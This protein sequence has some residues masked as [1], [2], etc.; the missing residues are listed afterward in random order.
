MLSYN[1]QQKR[2]IL[3]EYGRNIQR[4]VDYCLTIPDRE[5]R[6]RCAY[7]IVVSM[8]N[9]FPEL[10]DNPDNRHKLWDH[11][12]IMS[13]FKLDIDYPCEV[14]QAENLTT[15]PA[16]VPYSVQ[17]IRHRHYGKALERLID[18][19]VRMDDGEEKDE[20]IR[21]IAN[22][23]KKLML[24][25]NKEGVDD[26]KVFKDLAEMSHGMIRIDPSQM[27]LHEFRAA[28]AP[29]SGKKKRKK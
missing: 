20:L 21:L 17:T 13:G 15:P 19:A 25:V 18:T 22:H 11:L 7:T 12:A 28:P 2:L 8:A 1:T 10:R 14:I 9:L 27:Q 16:K 24:A 26:A 29:V 6:T 3:P 23:M 4:M 5:E